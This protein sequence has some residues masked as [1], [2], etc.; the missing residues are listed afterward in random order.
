MLVIQIV[1]YYLY[2]YSVP[3]F[4]FL[5]SLVA[6]C[7]GVFLLLAVVTIDI[8]SCQMAY[9]DVNV[10]AYISSELFGFP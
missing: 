6:D 3:I 8:V 1:A 10:S 7:I 2:L 4:V 9:G 5:L